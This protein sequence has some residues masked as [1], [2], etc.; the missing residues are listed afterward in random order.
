MANPALAPVKNGLPPIEMI[1]HRF[2]KLPRGV[3]Q[4]GAHNGREIPKLHRSGVMRGV[5]IDPLD[6]TFGLLQERAEVCEGYQTIQA[7]VG[8]DDGKEVEFHIAS[9]KGES[10]SFLT[11]GRHL[12][13]KPG[14]QFDAPQKRTL[15][16]LDSLLEEHHIDAGDFDMMFI[17]TQGAEMHV[18][19][20]AMS[21]LKHIKYIWME[22]GI[23]NIYEGDTSLARFIA[24]MDAMNFE[25]AFCELKRLGW[26]D[27]LFVHRSQFMGL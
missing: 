3:I 9:N 27:A 25:V 12:D 4:V 1:K 22:V 19:R 18:L 26:G 23:G 16:T 11:P 7:L 17:D 13:I 14:I 2:K 10:S 20:G 15:R 8:D 21:T 24:F 6:E 5:F